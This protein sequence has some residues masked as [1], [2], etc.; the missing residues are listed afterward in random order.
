M[1]LLQEAFSE[2]LDDRGSNTFLMGRFVF[3]KLIFSKYKGLCQIENQTK[4]IKTVSDGDRCEG[5]LTEISIALQLAMTHELKCPI[6]TNRETFSI[7]E[8]LLKRILQKKG[9]K[10]QRALIKRFQE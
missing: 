6:K 8:F 10:Q 7:K 2:E 3:F 4:K 5:A 1:I 9:S